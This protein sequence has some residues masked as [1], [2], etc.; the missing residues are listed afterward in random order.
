MSYVLVMM[1]WLNGRWVEFY[2]PPISKEQ[3]MAI[4]R[5]RHAT[6]AYKHQDSAMFCTPAWALEKP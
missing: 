4:I 6:A 1:F 5:A 2:L 3:C